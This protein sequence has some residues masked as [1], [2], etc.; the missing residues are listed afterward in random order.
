MSLPHCCREPPS[1]PSGKRRQLK[2]SRRLPFVEVEQKSIG[3]LP[4]GTSFAAMAEVVGIKGIRIETP[5]EVDR[6]IA[7][8]LAL[9]GAV[10]A[11]TELPI[12]RRRASSWLP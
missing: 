2:P 5:E 7:A 4:T 6:G 1:S 11:R 10:V 12:P 8:A 9:A 3:F